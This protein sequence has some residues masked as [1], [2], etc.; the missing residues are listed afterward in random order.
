MYLMDTAM[1]L[2]I[3]GVVLFNEHKLKTKMT[4]WLRLRPQ[5]LYVKTIHAW[6][7]IRPT[8]L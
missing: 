5:N 2:Q 8:D 3:C 7:Y 1:R 4:C 6:R